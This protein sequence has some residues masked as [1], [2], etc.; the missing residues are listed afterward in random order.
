MSYLEPLGVLHSPFW[1][2][3]VEP[4]WLSRK[5][6]NDLKNPLNNSLSLEA[7]KTEIP[8]VY[9][10][11]NKQVTHGPQSL[12]KIII[13]LVKLSVLFIC[14]YILEDLVYDVYDDLSGRR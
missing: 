4:A 8:A 5:T 14:K 9:L 10:K 12:G 3:Y 11:K 1:R 6:F 7:N 2:F 13:Y